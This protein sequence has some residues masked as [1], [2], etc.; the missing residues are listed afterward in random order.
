MWI[1]NLYTKPCHYG[2]PLAWP[3]VGD[4][5]CHDSLLRNPG[6]QLDG[7]SVTW[8]MVPTCGLVFKKPI[9]SLGLFE[10]LVKHLEILRRFDLKNHVGISYPRGRKPVNF[11][12][13]TWLSAPG[14]CFDQWHVRPRSRP[15]EEEW[16]DA[17]HVFALGL[18]GPILREE[19]NKNLLHPNEAC[20]KMH[21]YLLAPNSQRTWESNMCWRINLVLHC[22]TASGYGTTSQG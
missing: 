5:I 22:H 20:I 9:G 12:W 16:V 1:L 10:S 4:Q 17:L 13:F 19:K 11:W 7:N 8:G 6:W 18:W 21:V 15:Q 14:S 3:I 2:L